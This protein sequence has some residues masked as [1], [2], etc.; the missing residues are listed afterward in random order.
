[1][2]FVLLGVLFAIAIAEFAFLFF[3]NAQDR[4]AISFTTQIQVSSQ[5]LSKYASEAASGNE[6]AFKE[7][8]STSKNMD[9]YVDALNKGDPKTGMPSY[10][11]KPASRRRSPR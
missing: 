2:L 9:V 11:E 6:S 8:E 4:Q 5:Q 1:V 7:L 3:K 10:A